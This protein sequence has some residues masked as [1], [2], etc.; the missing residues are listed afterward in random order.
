MEISIDAPEGHHAP[1][2]TTVSVR[3]GASQRQWRLS[4][5]PRTYKV[6]EPPD[7]SVPHARVDVYRRIGG[8]SVPLEEDGG[9]ENFDVP[10]SDPALPSLRLR[11]GAK[12][13]SGAKAPS[14]VEKAR[15]N[16]LRA[17]EAHSYLVRHNLE[18]FLSEIMREVVRQKPDDPR[19][20]LASRILGNQSGVGAGSS[21][22]PPL[23]AVTPAEARPPKIPAR[24]PSPGGAPWRSRSRLASADEEVRP[25]LM[26]QSRSAP[27]LSSSSVA[28]KRSLGTASRREESPDDDCSFAAVE[29]I[30][31][32]SF[33]LVT[34]SHVVMP[35]AQVHG[36]PRP[37][38]A[39][40]TFRAL[41]VHSMALAKPCGA[42]VEQDAPEACWQ[43]FGRPLLIGHQMKHSDLSE[44]MPTAPRPMYEI[45]RKPA[46]PLPALAR[47][48]A[49]A[50]SN[51]YL[52]NADSSARPHGDRH[53]FCTATAP[54][55]LY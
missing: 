52:V 25:P 21:S 16:K 13:A 7:G 28:P 40:P 22:L 50:T 49:A 1:A 44:M 15:R 55:G 45:D 39:S 38:D 10:C 3:I 11:V 37:P 34:P 43:H 33:A 24:S 26:A 2:D 54:S 8:I 5:L 51:P 17:D 36:L 12:S 48:M 47:K 29:L 53:A 19:K 23:A 20:F 30:W 18:E 14:S 9:P 32:K 6:P 27:S 31:P 4:A 41:D 42:V 46:T 35:M